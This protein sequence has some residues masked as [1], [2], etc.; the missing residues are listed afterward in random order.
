MRLLR[1][2]HHAVLH[3]SR[4]GRAAEIIAWSNGV[5]GLALGGLVGWLTWSRGVTTALGVGLAAA[6]IAFCMLRLALAHRVTV[7]IAAVLGTS[8]VAAIG[9]G[10]AWVFAHLFESVPGLPPAAAALGAVLAG[11]LPA[12]SY[13]K[14]ARHRAHDVRDSL[15][16]ISLPHSR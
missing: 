5:T 3:E 1:A 13:R 9:G 10:L 4:E 15:M 14:L 7:W 16:P 8:S 6:A 2:L 11:L 12:M